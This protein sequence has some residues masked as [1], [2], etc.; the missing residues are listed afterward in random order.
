MMGPTIFILFSN[1]KRA[2]LD[3]GV[4]A[5]CKTRETNKI[6]SAWKAVYNKSYNE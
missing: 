1:I 5:P 3:T 2:N 6:A 4:G